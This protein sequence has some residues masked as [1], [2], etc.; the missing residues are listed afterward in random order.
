MS[1]DASRKDFSD[2]PKSLMS[3]ASV[4]EEISAGVGRVFSSD[5]Y[6][7]A[8]RCDATGQLQFKDANGTVGTYNVPVRT[9][10]NTF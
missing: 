7:K 1:R 5:E 6:P 4:H 2:T 3:Q 10:N 8:I 9:H